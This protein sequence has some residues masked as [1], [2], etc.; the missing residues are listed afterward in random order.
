MGTI[1]RGGQPVAEILTLEVRNSHDS[2]ASAIGPAEAWLEQQGAG[3]DAA[4]LALLAIE[5]LVS[6]CMKYAYDDQAEHVIQVVFAVEDETLTITVVDDGRPF[7]PLTAPPPDLDLP[8]E[9]R[10]AGGLGIY[11]LRSMADTMRYERSNGTNR[12]T[13]TRRL[14]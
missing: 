2:I 12:V 8:V 13:L 6:N 9:E 10:A 5:E 7:D 11:L 3:P 1:P 14:A 4:Y